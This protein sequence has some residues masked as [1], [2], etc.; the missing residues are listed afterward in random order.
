MIYKRTFYKKFP[1]SVGNF[2]YTSYNLPM[3]LLYKI[4]YY[5]FIVLLNMESFFE[6][7]LLLI[8][9]TSDIRDVENYFYPY[10]FVQMKGLCHDTRRR[11]Q[12]VRG[13]ET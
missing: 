2:F 4:Q 10:G 3:D 6:K 11:T 8:G 12:R 13:R 1:T 9:K 7:A 5:N